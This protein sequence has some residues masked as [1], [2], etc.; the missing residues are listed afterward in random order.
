[1][2]YNDPANIMYTFFGSEENTVYRSL[3]YP[4]GDVIRRVQDARGIPDE[5]ERLKEYAAL[6]KK[7]IRE[8]ASWIPLFSRTHLYVTGERVEHFETA[9]NGWC[10]PAYSRITLKQK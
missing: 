7:I 10:E 5:K 9:W 6:E 2:D 3:C 4:D 1:M 8:D